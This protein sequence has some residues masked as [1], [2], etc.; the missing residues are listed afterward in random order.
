MTEAGSEVRSFVA[1]DGYPLHVGS[2]RRSARSAGRSW[3]CTGFRATAAGI[4][5][6]D[7]RWPTP[8]TTRHF[9]TGAAR[10]RTRSIAATPD[11]PR[12]LNLDLVEW[13]RTRAPRAPRAAGC[14]GRHQLGRKARRDRRG[15]ASRAGRRPRAHLPRASSPA[16]ASHERSVFE[17][18]WA[19]LTNRRKTFP[20]PLSDP[21]LFTANPAGQAFIAGRPLQSS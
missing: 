6:W 21:A 14:T 13:L 5:G 1:S 20:I 7:G 15:P 11:R 4:T 17:I 12:R 2:G 19:F 10:E 9:P 3:Y 16:S 18:A 8:V